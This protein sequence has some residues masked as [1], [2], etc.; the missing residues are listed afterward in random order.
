VA[1]L[2]RGVLTESKVAELAGF[3]AKIIVGPEAVVTPLA[4]DKARELKI[5]IERHKP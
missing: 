5:A 1:R 2:E 3:H 4:R